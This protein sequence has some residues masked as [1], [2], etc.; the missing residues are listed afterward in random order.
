MMILSALNPSED[1]LLKFDDTRTFTQKL[2]LI[3][4]KKCEWFA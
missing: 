3:M 4:V 1:V 2:L